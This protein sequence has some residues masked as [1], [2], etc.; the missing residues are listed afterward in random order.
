MTADPTPQQEHCA[1]C[2]DRGWIFCAPDGDER[3][4]Y[5]QRCDGCE[6][7][8]DTDVEAAYSALLYC[9]KHGRP[10][11]TVGASFDPHREEDGSVDPE[12]GSHPYL[13]GF[14]TLDAAEQW[15]QKSQSGHEHRPRYYAAQITVGTSGAIFRVPCEVPGC[16]ARV[17][18]SL[19]AWD[20][21]QWAMNAPVADM[22][23]HDPSRLRW[24]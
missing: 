7:A 21:L 12:C 16:G 10:D 15:L 3:R 24:R 23:R 22:R 14:A 6:H 9:Q 19:G 17:T 5:V 4:P 11:V 20:A 2:D 1:S 13:A 18:I 8:A